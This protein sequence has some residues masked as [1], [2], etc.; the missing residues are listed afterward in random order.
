MISIDVLFFFQNLGHLPHSIPQILINRDPIT[1]VNFDI[2]LLGDGDTIVKYLCSKLPPSFDLSS[3]KLENDPP[4][5]SKT[6][7]ELQEE[8]ERIN[9]IIPERVGE[10]N[11]WTFP[12]AN[13]G[14]WVER[15]RESYNDETEEE[16]NSNQSG[17]GGG[18][19]EVPES[20][21]R[22][23]S[24]SEAGSDDEEQEEGL[25]KKIKVM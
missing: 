11:V 3:I 20:E 15:I 1:H 5:N 13:G 10:S 12:G 2:H 16:D 4:S 7:Q 18:G 22:S 17:E 23:R 9:K 14:K 19:L 21:S 25:S 8:E 6:D 24:R